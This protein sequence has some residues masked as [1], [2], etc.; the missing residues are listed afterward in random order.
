MLFLL[1]LTTIGCQVRHVEQTIWI[2]SAI[3][4][5]GREGCDS[6][7]YLVLERYVTAEGVK[8]SID[9]LAL[10]RIRERD[11]INAYVPGGHVWMTEDQVRV[12]RGW[13]RLML[14]VGSEAMDRR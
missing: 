10:R 1:L 12:G 2:G 4:V 14:G 9:Q 11:S 7:E 5:L 13:P 3:D 8:V 6:I